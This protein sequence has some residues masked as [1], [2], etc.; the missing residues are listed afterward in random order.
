MKQ[1]I[2]ALAAAMLSASLAL[3]APGNG[4][5]GVGNGNGNGN[6]NAHHAAP[7]PVLGAGLPALAAGGIGYGIYWL[8][9]RRRRVD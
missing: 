2:I 9:R 6:G 3:A 5:G 4:N 1:F 7:G 8:V